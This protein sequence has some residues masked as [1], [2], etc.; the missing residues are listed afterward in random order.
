ML[1]IFNGVALIF[2]HQLFRLTFKSKVKD[3]LIVRICDKYSLNSNIICNYISEF[4]KKF[5]E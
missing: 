5:I 2:A 1:R 3:I 4:R